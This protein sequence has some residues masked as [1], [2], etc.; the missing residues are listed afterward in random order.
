MGANM[1]TS[2]FVFEL[3]GHQVN[4][5]PEAL[6]I[7]IIID[8]S[9]YKVFLKNENG[10]QVISLIVP[11]PENQ[12]YKTLIKH[13]LSQYREMK[14]LYEESKIKAAENEESCF[15]E[16]LSIKDKVVLISSTSIRFNNCYTIKFE[17]KEYKVF[18]EVGKDIDGR[19]DHKYV[20][21]VY[22]DQSEPSLKDV[23]ED[24]E[25][26]KEAII[27]KSANQKKFF[28]FRV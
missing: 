22:L 25:I 13:A 1:S 20:E 7:R 11:I 21:V 28:E 14:E 12:Q 9:E 2:D 8:E 6:C 17:E 16:R 3:D 15:F 19:Y 27:S 24:I 10:Q 5:I 23:S 26:I 18:S 4:V